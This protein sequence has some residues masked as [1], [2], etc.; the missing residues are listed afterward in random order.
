MRNHW[1]VMNHA[2]VRLEGRFYRAMGDVVLDNPH[3]NDMITK[4]NISDIAASWAPGQKLTEAHVMGLE[5]TQ[6]DGGVQ[7]NP[8]PDDNPNARAVNLAEAVM[9]ATGQMVVGVEDIDSSNGGLSPR[10]LDG[11][12]LDGD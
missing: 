2:K 3:L 10:E 9:T 5:P 7:L 4:D 8:F 11:F 6:D 12:R 1:S